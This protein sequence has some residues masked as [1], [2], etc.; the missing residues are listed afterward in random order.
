MLAIVIVKP[1]QVTIVKAV[2]LNSGAAVCATNADICGESAATEIPQMV[3]N[4]RKTYGE[5]LKNKK[6]IN[7][8][9]PDISKA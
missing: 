7:E 2:P 1:V 3:M 8:Q 6:Q 9:I 5:E 4:G